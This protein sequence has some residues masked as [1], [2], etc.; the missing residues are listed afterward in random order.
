[1]SKANFEAV[2]V[3]IWTFLL[4]GENKR[5]Q[6][7]TELRAIVFKWSCMQKGWRRGSSADNMT[8]ANRKLVSSLYGNFGNDN[9]KMLFVWGIDHQHLDFLFWFYL[10]VQI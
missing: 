2:K 5:Q 1:M 6:S 9:L 7:A 3:L 4:N 8:G 10:F